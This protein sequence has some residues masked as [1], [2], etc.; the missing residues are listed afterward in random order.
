M[1]VKPMDTILQWNGVS[2]VNMSYEQVANLI[3]NSG[4]TAELLIEPYIR[5]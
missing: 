1:N 5:E 4:D 3:A 2:L